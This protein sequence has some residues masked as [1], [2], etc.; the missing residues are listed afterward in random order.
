[1]S[2][3]QA[4]WLEG[5]CMNIVGNSRPSI[6]GSGLSSASIDGAESGQSVSQGQ[7]DG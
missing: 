7:R 4:V 6:D 1:M 3:F 5:S 2:R